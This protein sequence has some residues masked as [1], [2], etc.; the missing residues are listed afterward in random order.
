MRQVF[1]TILQHAIFC[2]LGGNGPYRSIEEVEIMKYTSGVLSETLFS[3]GAILHRVRAQTRTCTLS[4]GKVCTFVA[5]KAYKCWEDEGE[6]SV[7]DEGQT[8]ETF[9][10]L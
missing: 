2:R 8:T 1:P 4:P 6:G 3:E 10:A 5:P 9:T 7:T